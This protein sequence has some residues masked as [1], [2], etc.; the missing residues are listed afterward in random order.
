MDFDFL[1]ARGLIG[2][3]MEGGLEDDF[4]RMEERIRALRRGVDGGLATMLSRQ[5]QEP[6][7]TVWRPGSGLRLTCIF[8]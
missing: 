1:A 7:G 3:R 5:A 2:A 4:S 6:T 8:W